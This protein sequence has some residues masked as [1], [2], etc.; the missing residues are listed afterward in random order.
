MFNKNIKFKLLK[1]VFKSKIPLGLYDIRNN[2]I[3]KF[4]YQVELSKYLNLHKSTIGRYL[5]TGKLLLSKYY[6]RK[7]NDN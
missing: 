4:I 2:L 6:I 1:N 5:K 7:I 3:N